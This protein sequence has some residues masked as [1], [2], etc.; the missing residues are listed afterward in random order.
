MTGS[1]ASIVAMLVR[2]AVWLVKRDAMRLKQK[3][4]SVPADGCMCEHCQWVRGLE[5]EADEK[6][7]AGWRP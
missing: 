3:H 5:A 2:V 7:G 4:F 6:L 1:L